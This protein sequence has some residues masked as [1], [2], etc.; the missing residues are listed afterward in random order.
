LPSIQ[1]EV[2]VIVRAQTEI[3]LIAETDQVRHEFGLLESR[4][5][6]LLVPPQQ[7]SIDDA[8]SEGA[9]N[10]LTT[11]Q[12]IV[13]ELAAALPTRE[14]LPGI[15]IDEVFLKAF[16]HQLADAGFRIRQGRIIWK[17]TTFISLDLEDWRASRLASGGHVRRA[18][19]GDGGE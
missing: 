15:P 19:A 14:G 10:T 17:I 9:P 6:P 13:R 5:L 11:W 1:Q 2:L 12:H 3:D 8:T 16:L 7:A 18:G 4:I